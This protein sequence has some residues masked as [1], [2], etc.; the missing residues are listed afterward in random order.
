MY[1]VCVNATCKKC[2][3][4]EYTKLCRFHFSLSDPTKTTVSGT[5]ETNVIS[6]EL[7]RPLSTTSRDL[8]TGMSAP[9]DRRNAA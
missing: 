5:T 7:E 2:I 6:T 9:F 3:G 1:I 8:A 4:F